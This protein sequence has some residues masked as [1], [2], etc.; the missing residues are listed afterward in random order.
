MTYNPSKTVYRDGDVVAR[1]EWQFVPGRLTGSAGLRLDYNSY[2][3]V[4]YQPSARLLYTPDSRQSAWVAASRAVRAP[5]RVD[6]DF[7]ENAGAMVVQGMP[8]ALWM[9]GS[10][11]MTSEVE[12]SLEAGYRYQSGQRWSVDWSV[13]WSYYERLRA[14]AGSLMPAL[15][16]EGGMPVLTSNVYTCNCGAGRSYGTEIWGTWQVRPGGGSALRIRI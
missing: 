2:H 12:R 13:Y 9:Y 15:S 7:Q 6:R 14:V 11:S 16:F 10:K 1:D 8:V 4:E 5:N 3:Q